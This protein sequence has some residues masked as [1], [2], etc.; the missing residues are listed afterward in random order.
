LDI[1][2]YGGLWSRTEGSQKIDRQIGASGI[3]VTEAGIRQQQRQLLR[4]DPL[5]GVSLVDA[6]VVTLTSLGIHLLTTAPDIA[7]TT[8]PDPSSPFIS[9]ALQASPTEFRST[10]LGAF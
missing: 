6:S 9:V 5:A 1:V 2:K 7:G 10:F 8:Q 3:S 4:M